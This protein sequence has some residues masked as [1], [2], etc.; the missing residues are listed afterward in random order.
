MARPPRNHTRRC[1]EAAASALVVASTLLAAP[2]AGFAL[3]L[4]APPV[5]IDCGADAGGDGLRTLRGEAPALRVEEAPAVL[6]A[7]RPVL[8]HSEW[9]VGKGD[10]AIRATILIEAFAGRGLGLAFDGGKVELDHAEAAAILRGTLFGGGS[11]TLAESRPAA[12]R[13]G[14][15]FE[16][17]LARLDGR[18]VLSLDGIEA[19][20]IGMRDIALGRLGFALGGAELRVLAC[21]IEGDI[22]AMPLPRSV[23]ETP[24]GEIDEHRDPVLASDGKTALLGAIAVVTRDDGSLAQSL[25]LRRLDE[26][27]TITAAATADLGGLEPELA[28]LGHDGERWILAVQSDLERGFARRVELLTSEDGRAFGQRTTL[29][30]PPMRLASGSASRLADGSLAFT[31][32]IVGAD[33]PRPAL[34][35]RAAGAWR[36]RPISEEASGEPVVLDG[37][38]VLVRR[39]GSLDRA[40]LSLPAND[41]QAEPAAPAEGFQGAAIAPA[42]IAGPSGRIAA[43]QPASTFPNPLSILATSDRG[44]HWTTLPNLWGGPSGAVNAVAHGDGWLVLFE[45]GDATRREHVLLVRLAAPEVTRILGGQPTDGATTAESIQTGS[46]SPPTRP[47]P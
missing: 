6:G 30:T 43:L 4:S 34:L 12:V 39:A 1:A 14:A 20:S 2:G 24:E 26:A 27:G 23:F 3:P 11:F 8:H 21:E 13:P 36:V 35:V 33:G 40:L 44:S 16:F 17:A 47:Q 45:G 7:A 38:R 32:T 29:E 10:F 37:A 22:L 28:A 5:P 18:L 19:G 46:V 42:V 25:R 9:L 41:G 31:A 15:P